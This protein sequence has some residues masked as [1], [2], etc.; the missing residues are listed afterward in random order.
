KKIGWLSVLALCL[1]MIVAVIISSFMSKPLIQLTELL[2]SVGEGK[3]VQGKVINTRD[4]IGV[5]SKAFNSMILKLISDRDRREAAE[6]ALQQKNETLEKEIQHRHEIE[7]SLKDRNQYIETIL[8]NMPIGFALNTIKEEVFLYTN[9]KHVEIYGWSKDEIRTVNDIFD[10]IF[11][12]PDYRAEIRTRMREGIA[13]GDPKQ[14]RWNNL[15]VTRKDGKQIYVK[16]IDIL[17]PEQNL[18]ISTSQDTTAEKEAID[19]LNEY[20]QNLENIIEE[21]TKSLKEKTASYED[22]Q[23][24]LSYLLEDVNETR[25]EL[26]KTNTQLISVNKELE[27]FSYSVS[28]DLR[29][30]LRAIDGFSKAL[31]EDYGDKLD[32]EAIEYLEIIRKNAQTM[33]ILISDLLEFSRL[34]RKDIKLLEIDMNE[35]I[36]D[37]VSEI[38]FQN[39]DKKIEV[40]L[41]E[42]SIVKAD[43]AMLHQVLRNLVSNAVKYSKTRPLIKIEFACQETEN[44]YIFSI[45]DNGIGF[46]MKYYNKLFGVFQRLHS[47]MEYEGTGVGLAI[48]QRII[49]KHGGRVWAE[50][51]PDKGATFYFSLPK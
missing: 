23:L 50:A 16:I 34:S 41:P 51:E 29:A 39:Q 38:K 33:G 22:S 47:G 19:E 10:H 20:Q 45:R 25:N 31:E 8:D 13:T 2:G 1:V 43:R 18:L 11:T 35:I 15:R 4:E 42:R 37:V 21:R 28:H 9:K 26:L 44:E 36:E 14:M 32:E 49:V 17:L 27:A 5:L 30:P 48:V 12:D 46:D 3:L 7:E 40:L 24:A 6:V